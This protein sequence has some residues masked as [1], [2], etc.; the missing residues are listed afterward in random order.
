ME[1]LYTYYSFSHESGYVV[2]EIPWYKPPKYS[3][4]LEFSNIIRMS[5]VI[6]TVVAPINIST[7]SE[8]LADAGT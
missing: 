6:M 8:R 2:G 4:I 3:N 5:S 1:A 7:K